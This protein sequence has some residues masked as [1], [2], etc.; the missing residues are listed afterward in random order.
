MNEAKAAHDQAVAQY[1]QTVL[2]AL[3]NVEDELAAS[4]VLDQQAELRRQAALAANAAEQMF[5]NRYKAGQVA[6]SDVIT[7]QTAAYSARRSLAQTTAQRQSTAVALIQSLGGG[8]K[9]R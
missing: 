2:S 3:Q 8:W 6:Y 5:L 9:V 1:R 7:A 4:K